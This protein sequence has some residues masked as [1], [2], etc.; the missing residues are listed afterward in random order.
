MKTFLSLALSLSMFFLFATCKKDPPYDPNGYYIRCK[1]NGQLYLPE[2]CANCMT[3][4][5]IGDTLLLIGANRGFETLVIGVRDS[6]SVHIGHFPLNNSYN[7]NAYYKNSPITYDIFRTDSFHTGQINILKLDK[8]LRIVE[9]NFEFMPY[10]NYRNSTVSIT[11]G[12][13]RLKF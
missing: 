6:L 13:F 5:L 1:V 9:G 12:I 10:N 3:C 4:D 7:H 11:E 8:G 2:N